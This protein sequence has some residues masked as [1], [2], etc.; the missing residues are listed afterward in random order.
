MSIQNDPIFVHNDYLHLLTEYGIAGA[1]CMAFLVVTHL[2]H[3]LRWFQR[4][5]KLELAQ[6]GEAS[7][8]RLALQIG[9]LSAM[10]AYLA[11]S[12]VDF[13]LHIPA[14]ALL[15]AFIFGMIANPGRETEP[16]PGDTPR[17]LPGGR[18]RR[19]GAGGDARLGEPAQTGRGVLCRIRPRGDP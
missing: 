18:A 2:T 1:I 9:A 3:G 19:A 4:I 11:H 14:N 10:S 16:A 8:H 15:M 12:V 17:L 5:T 7:S 13:N 6:R